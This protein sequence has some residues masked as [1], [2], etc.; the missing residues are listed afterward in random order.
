MPE[1]KTV[2]V[3]TTTT[4]TVEKFSIPQKQADEISEN[5]AGQELKVPEPQII[6]AV[7]K[8]PS[9]VKLIS[10]GAS[11]ISTLIA[12]TQYLEHEREQYDNLRV[13]EHLMRHYG[14]FHNVKRSRKV[15]DARFSHSVR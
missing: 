1:E 5:H 14:E 9:W 7:Q 13:R 10:V 3:T 4:E 8:R 12:I 11:I 2:I 6:E 15:H